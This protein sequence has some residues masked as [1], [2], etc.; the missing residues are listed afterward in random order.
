MTE[1]K[2]A[3]IVEAGPKL[4]IERASR[5]KSLDDLPALISVPRAAAI[6]GLTRATAYRYAAAGELPTRRFGGRRVYVVTAKLRALIET[7]G[8]AV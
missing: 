5:R 2:E 8:E 6:L 4:P 7:G 1:G 3:T